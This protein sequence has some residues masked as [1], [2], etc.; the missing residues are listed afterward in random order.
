RVSGRTKQA[1][2]DAVAARLA[3]V[4]KT[5]ALAAEAPEE[6]GEVLG[7]LA[8]AGPVVQGEHGYLPTEL[9]WAIER[10]LLVSDGW[11]SAEMPR[12]VSLALRGPGWPA[13]VVPH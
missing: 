10:G 7:A 11:D 3:D 1:A 8:T 2:I 9:R 6:L 13:E 12:E 4:E 5:A